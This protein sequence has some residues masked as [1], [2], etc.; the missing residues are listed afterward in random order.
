MEATVNK[1]FVDTKQ[2][3]KLFKVKSIW[4]GTKARFEE[5]NSKLAGALVEGA[6]KPETKERKL[7]LETKEVTPTATT[8]T[9]ATGKASTTAKATAQA[10]EMQA[11][12]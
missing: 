7:A 3:G 8:D 1:A 5:I 4:N 6:A 2:D 11:K 9:A 10:K 12:K